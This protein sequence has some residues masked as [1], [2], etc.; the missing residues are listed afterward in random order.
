M[1]AVV[2]LVDSVVQDVRYGARLLARS[3]WFTAVGVVSLAFGLGSGVALFTFMNALLFRPLAG[4]DTANLHAIYTSSG[5]GQRYGGSSFADFVSFTSADPALFAGACAS[6]NISANLIVDTTPLGLSGALV[7]GGCFDALRIR[8]RAGRVLHGGDDV[9]T[10]DP[11]AIVIS[12]ALWRRAFGADPDVVGRVGM[13]NGASVVIAGVAEEGFAGLSLDSAADFWVGAAMAPSLLSPRALIERTDRRF[14]IFVRL[15]DGVTTAQAGDRLAAVAAQLRVEDPR[16]WTD[17]KGRGRTVTVVPELEARF[18]SAHGAAQAIG[19][20]TIGAIAGIVALACI[21]LATIILARGAARRHEL[22][23][24][25]A[26]GA[27]R[28]RVLR[29]MAIESLLMSGLGVVVGI[30]F[31]AMG[32]RLFQAY[33][34]ADVPSFNL[35]V[36]WRVVAFAMLLAVVTPMLFG[37]LPGAHALRL[38]INEGLKGRTALMRRSF[39]RISSRELLIGVQLAASFAMLVLATLFM[40]SLRTVDFGRLLPSQAATAVVPIDINSPMP[41]D[42]D[43][44]ALTE[45]LLQAARRVPNVDGVT[46][47]SLI[48]MTG[49]FAGAGGFDDSGNAVS[50]DVNIVAPGYFDVIGTA[51]RA[52][53]DFDIRDHARAPRVAVVSES[54]ARERWHTTAAVG[55]TIRLDSGPVEVVGVVMDVPYRSISDPN[56]PVLYLPIAQRPQRRFIV[57]AR[58]R[59]EGE[60]MAALD[61]GLRDVNPRIMVGPATPLRHAYEQALIGERAAQWIGGAAGLLQLV[62]ALMAT[63]G[64]VAYAV[65]RRMVEIAI[66]RALGATEASILQLVMRPSLWLLAIGA[67]VGCAAGVVAARILQSQFSGFASIDLAVVLPAAGLLVPIVV[68]ASWLPARRAVAIAPALA[69]KN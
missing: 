40:Q 22:N 66:R 31:V 45:R 57:H 38:A 42:A 19:L 49:S 35:A 53:R 20:G 60:T 30:A 3:P 29:Q 12:H 37:V 1:R 26:L 56:Q 67:V 43:A 51:L 59:S 25:L 58:V 44:G 21:N 6:T 28:L 16:A 32:L 36:D 10:A 63:W 64:L 50:F 46:A 47:A 2:S 23:I 55:R 4:H 34:P 61:R 39:L 8:P 48:P 7:N 27:S 54:L 24:R 13:L 65:E 62:L 18:G 33:R 68:A 11:P 17:T 9:A 41:A 15:G 52:G 5:S 69:L 14:R